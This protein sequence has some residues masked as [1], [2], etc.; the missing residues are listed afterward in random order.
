MHE[1]SIA[2]SLVEMAEEEAAKRRGRVAVIHLKL[3][4]LSG[5]V[6]TALRSAYELARENTELRE[7]E[8]RIEEVPVAAFCSTCATE[9]EVAFPELR[10]PVCGE[11]TPEVVRGRELEVTALE[12]ES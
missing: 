8:L 3:G 1:L 5:V 2:M 10:C 12:I 4:P 11:A 6:P 9:R 7:A